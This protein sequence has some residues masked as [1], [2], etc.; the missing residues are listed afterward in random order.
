MNCP[1]CRTDLPAS[2]RSCPTCGSVIAFAP[3]VP[4]ARLGTPL[5]PW[6]QEAM[7]ARR[8]SLGYQQP[9]RPA[10]ALARP[11][12]SVVRS[13][14]RARQ[15]GSSI[16]AAAP[17]PPLLEGATLRQLGGQLLAVRGWAAVFA[18]LAVLPLLL[19]PVAHGEPSRTTWFFAGYFAFAWGAAMYWMI[20]P[21]RTDLWL[22]VRVVG[23]VV[24]GGGLLSVAVERAFAPDL[25][26]VGW[27]L[28]LALLEAIVTAAPLVV[29]LLMG[30]I[31]STPRAYLFLG[32]VSGLGFAVV[33]SVLRPA[34]T[35]PPSPVASWHL[36]NGTL[37]HGCFAAALAYTIA[38]AATRRE[39][40]VALV[41]VGTAVVG[42]LHGLGTR[43]SD[44][45][46]GA[47]TGVIAV[48]AFVACARTGDAI[49][50]AMDG[51]P[52][53]A[54][55]QLERTDAGPRGSHRST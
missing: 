31:S 17:V 20:Q 10:V 19:L 5:P 6:E 21:G 34:A 14:S 12:P 37:V 25:H 43:W 22:A 3:D 23:T 7:R 4:E 52:A 29:F 30:S 41:A 38:A 39:R 2:A 9:A 53:L 44:G 47:V 36:L 11:G 51:E 15:P 33:D 24:L 46:V 42:T 40:A 27:A 16:G 48:L 8:P 32:A 1:A 18:V 50:E 45:W 54:H 49:T 13:P 28:V 55:V 26:Q 35:P